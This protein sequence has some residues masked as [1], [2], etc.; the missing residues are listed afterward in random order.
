M[1]QHF[2]RMPIEFLV[3]Y[4]SRS[5]A[6]AKYNSTRSVVQVATP[7]PKKSVSSVQIGQ[8]RARAVAG[9][10]QSSSSRFSMRSCATTSKEAYV[11]AST[12]CPTALANQVSPSPEPPESSS[13]QSH[14]QGRLT[15]PAQIPDL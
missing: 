15:D 12:V 5:A 8:A 4:T 9:T 1:L 2:E 6:F 11:S 3:R 10:G 13:P 7:Q 14:S